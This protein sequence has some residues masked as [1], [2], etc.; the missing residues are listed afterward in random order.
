MGALL[1][2]I[3]GV[4]MG[5]AWAVVDDLTDGV[6]ERLPVPAGGVLVGAVALLGANGP[7]VALGVTDPR[8]WAL[9]D[10]VSD[11]LPHLA[12]GLVVAVAYQRP[13]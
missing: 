5:V 4:T 13:G 6:L 11:L 12:Y 7:M 1:G 3:T 9:A 8:G 2:T 10:W